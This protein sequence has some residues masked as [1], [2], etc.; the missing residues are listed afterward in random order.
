M[1]SAYELAMERMNKSNPKTSAPLTAKQKEALAE[2]DRI[3]KAKIAEKEL[4]LQPKMDAARAEG[5]GT[6]FESLQKQLRDE[7]S[8]LREELEREKEK[9][10][11]NK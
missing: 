9:V 8:S 6:A 5:D 2:T 4:F 11:Q 7:I 1:K 10:R 3:Y